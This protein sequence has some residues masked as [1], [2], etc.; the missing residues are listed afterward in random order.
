MFTIRLKD[1]DYKGKNISLSNFSDS[2]KS[3]IRKALESIN[4]LSVKE[5]EARGAIIFPSKSTENDL[6]D[7][8][9]IVLSVHNLE[10]DNPIIKTSN[11]MG[12]FAIENCLNIEIHSRFDSDDRQF[13][14]H[15]M[16]QKIC[17]V[18]P[19]VEL[20]HVNK[21][22]FYEFIV[23]LFPSFLNRAISQGLFRSYITK[24]YNDSNIRG[25]IEFP[26][27]FKNNIPFNGK[28]AYRTREYNQDNY[29][30]QLIRHTIEFIAENKN[31]SNIL[32][33]DEEIND[34]VQIIRG[35]TGSYN[36]FSR[37]FIINKN[38]KTITHPYYTEYEPLRKLCIMILTHD[39][40]S[41]GEK[42]QTK[43]NGILFDGA[44]LWEEYI[45]MIMI[46]R[47]NELSFPYILEHPNNRTGKGIKYLFETAENH[48]YT[49]IYPDFIIKNPDKKNIKI[50]ADAK[51]KHLED[52]SIPRE[53]YFQLLSYL[54]RF[55][56][57]QGMLIYP[58][59]QK[60][61]TSDSNLFLAEHKK[62]IRLSVNGLK[63]IKYDDKCDF[64]D[65]SNNMKQKE[66][67]FVIKL[68]V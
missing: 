6:N 48:N 59:S 45:N 67:E 25:V 20:T 30:T 15:Y 68:L 23:Y 2:E 29:V 5:L 49:A 47:L 57:K 55:D 51:Y 37:N 62:E 7:G 26:R 10:T 18:S 65:F 11:V 1:N 41:Y 19:T 34:S 58:Y 35:C 27:H 24:N 28:V 52:A 21:N 38:T 22:P 39:K 43:L 44:S 16:L 63:I 3:C 53:D 61:K 9:K 12:F 42:Q 40:I 14:L 31:L 50:I 33:I 60:D 56:C 4:N 54:F 46:E 8:G 13:F 66:E 17:N 64:K 36:R 32:N